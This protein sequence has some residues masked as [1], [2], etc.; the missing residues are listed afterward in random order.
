MG[1]GGQQWDI[2]N[3]RSGA[4]DAVGGILRILCR[5]SKRLQRNVPRDRQD[6]KP[7]ANFCEECFC[8]RGQSDSI[9]TGELCDF[10]QRDSRYRQAEFFL[11]RLLDR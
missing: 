2:F 10:Y 7:A 1:I 4:N 8:V 5:E 11:T 6:S 9:A 3:Q